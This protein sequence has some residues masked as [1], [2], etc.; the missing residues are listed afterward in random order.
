MELVF[1]G[2]RG[3]ET[4]LRKPALVLPLSVNVVNQPPTFFSSLRYLAIATF[5]AAQCFDS[6][7]CYER[8]HHECARG[9]G[10]PEIEQ[11]VQD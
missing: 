4:F 2:W 8:N 3:S 11:S 1:R 7:S 9:V 5:L 10:P 6:L